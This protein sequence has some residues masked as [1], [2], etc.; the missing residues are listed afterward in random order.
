MC[1]LYVRIYVRLYKI[2]R[3]YM[4]YVLIC[5]YCGM[6]FGVSVGWPAPY[7]RPRDADKYYVG[8]ALEMPLYVLL[9]SYARLS[10]VYIHVYYLSTFSFLFNFELNLCRSL[11]FVCRFVYI[12]YGKGARWLSISIEKATSSSFHPQ[13]AGQYVRPLGT[14]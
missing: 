4:N 14:G 11:C 7:P 12:S 5:L 2:Y 10:R 3:V 6:R 9:D 13:R 8:P 1:N